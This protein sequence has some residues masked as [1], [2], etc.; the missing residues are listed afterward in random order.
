MESALNR[1]V[2]EMFSTRLRPVAQYF[3]DEKERV[4]SL[5]TNIET[6]KQQFINLSEFEEF[7]NNRQM[8][9][10][11]VGAG[12][13][14]YLVHQAMDSVTDSDRLKEFRADAESARALRSKCD[15][16]LK[17][18]LANN[19]ESARTYLQS[20]LR[21]LEERVAMFAQRS[22]ASPMVI[23]FGPQTELERCRVNECLSILQQ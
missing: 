6:Q 21:V 2:I 4:T 14:R 15:H 9:E 16:I 7:R 20:R 13:P 3:L 18:I 19:C 12:I 5:E 23:R 1:F 11:L 22:P 17:D 8:I 10:S